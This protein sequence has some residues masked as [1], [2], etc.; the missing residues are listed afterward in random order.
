MLTIPRLPLELHIK[1][2]IFHVLIKN[3]HKHPIED[4]TNNTDN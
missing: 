3:K 2:N 4:Y 1:K